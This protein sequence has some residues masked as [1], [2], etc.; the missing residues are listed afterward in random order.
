MGKERLRV[1]AQEAWR[2]AVCCID[3]T[4]YKSILSASP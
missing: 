1:S 4:L 2:L 3:E